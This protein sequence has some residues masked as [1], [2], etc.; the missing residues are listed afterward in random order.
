[1]QHT[2]EKRSQFGP[3]IKPETLSLKLGSDRGELLANEKY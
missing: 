3:F 1:M 2:R